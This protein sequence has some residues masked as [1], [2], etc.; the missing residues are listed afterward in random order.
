[1]KTCSGL[2]LLLL[3]AVCT[4]AQAQLF[5]GNDFFAN[6]PKPPELYLE[7]AKK[8]AVLNFVDENNKQASY[9]NPVKDNGAKLADALTANLLKSDFGI[10]E[11]KGL[12]IDGFRTNI[13]TVVER[14]QLDNVLREQKL[15]ASGAIGDSEASQAGKLLGLDVIVSGGLSYKSQDSKSVSSTKDDKGVVTY[16]YTVKREVVVEV[17]VKFI[18]VESGQILSLKTFTKLST[19][20]KTNSSPLSYDVLQAP[21]S[22][23]NTACDLVSSDIMVY[24]CPT[25]QFQ[26]LDIWRIKNKEF[27]EKASEAVDFLKDRKVDRAL[28]TF[29]SIY[30]QDSY[31]PAIANNVAVLYEG[32][33]NYE[34]ALEYYKIASELDPSEKDLKKG[35]Q[36]AEAGLVL[37]KY[38]AGH[39]VELKPYSFAEAGS[40]SSALA[41]KITTRGNSKDRYEVRESGDATSA[42]VAKIPG[43][44]AFEIIEKTSGWFKIKLIG[45]KMGYIEAKNVKE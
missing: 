24:M 13:F 3:L 18:K 29:I 16:Y 5:G 7:G 17:R 2:L 15:G 25:Y 14:S 38:L 43:G 21:E 35:V 27:K 30:E 11:G 40:G 20:S 23:A 34:K 28:L 32:T 42:V 36:R 26:Q 4:I 19:D 33:G 6:T 41:D 8:I 12:Y 9:W 10:T 31:S 44:I 45:G 1:M 22:L 39:G 37:V